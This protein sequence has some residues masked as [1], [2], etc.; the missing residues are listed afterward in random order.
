MKKAVVDYGETDLSAFQPQ[1][2]PIAIGVEAAIPAPVE[3]LDPSESQP[4]QKSDEPA[5][6]PAKRAKTAKRVNPDEEEYPWEHGNPKVPKVFNLRLNEIE[7]AQLKFVGDSTYGESM[8]S[9]AK[10][11]VMAEVRRRLKQRGIIV[12]DT[13]E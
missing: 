1:V 12:K 13:K 5:G 8:H 9:I 2:K 4:T 11:S 10:D 3:P 7:L 6:A